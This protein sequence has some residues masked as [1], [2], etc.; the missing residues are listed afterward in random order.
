MNTTSDVLT[1][2]AFTGLLAVIVA[3]VGWWVK[4][5]WQMIQ[6]L[7]S[8]VTDLNIKLAENYVPRQELEAR[9]GRI[10]DLL[11]SIRSTQLKSTG[12]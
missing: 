7:Q 3:G 8:Q 4:N 2:P 9:L 11:E 6:S 12:G 10:L 1:H 5:M